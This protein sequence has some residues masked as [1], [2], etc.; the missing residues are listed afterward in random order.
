[1]TQLESGE[2]L[3]VMRLG[4]WHPLY[5]TQST[6]GGRTWTSPRAL[7]VWGIMPTVLALPCGA[8]ALVSGRPHVTLSFSLD[9]GY[10]WPYTIR[11]LEDGKPED[12]ST[13]NTAMI[14]VEPNRLL[15]MYDHG[16]YHP[17]PEEFKGK[18]RIVGHFID[19]E[20]AQ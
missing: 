16:G 9:R 4:S 10:R 19:I 8:V 2:L 7:P 20:L 14:Q 6:D 1:M 15:H 17:L 18:R 13:R 3:L 5:A 12:P 11:F